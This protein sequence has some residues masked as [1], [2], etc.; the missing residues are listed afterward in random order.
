MSPLKLLTAED[1]YLCE[2]AKAVLAELDIPF[3]EIS[4]DSEEGQRLAAGAPPLRPVLYG[5]Q[6][7]MLAYGRLSARRLRTQR[8]R[9]E[10]V[11]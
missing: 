8:D 9:E 4:P 7:R 3:V 2:H 10:L 11:R 6:D 1:C 5:P